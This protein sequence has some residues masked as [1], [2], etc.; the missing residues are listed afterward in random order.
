MTW[1]KRYQTHETVY[2]INFMMGITIITT[3]GNKDTKIMHQ[4]LQIF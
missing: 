1:Q 3:N 4:L 2:N